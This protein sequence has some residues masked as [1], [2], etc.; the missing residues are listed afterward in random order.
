MNTERFPF[1]NARTGHFGKLRTS[2]ALVGVVAL[3]GATT[4]ACA[5]RV[6]GGTEAQPPSLSFGSDSAA[7]MESSAKSDA[8]RN[9]M[10]A[11]AGAPAAAPAPTGGGDAAQSSISDRMIVYNTSISLA[12]DNVQESVNAVSALAQ[13]AGGIVSG[14][15]I[16][17]DD[18]KKEQATLTLRVPS[19]SYYEVM[20]NLRKLGARVLNETGSTQDVTEEFTDLDA[21]LRNF[22]ATEAQYLELLKRAQTIDEILKVQNQLTQIRG[23]IERTKGRMNLL[24]RTSDMATIAVTMT[25]VTPGILQEPTNAWDPARTVRE[26]WETSLVFVRAFADVSIRVVIFSWWLLPFAALLWVAWTVRRR[27]PEPANPS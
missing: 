19:S 15:S 24:Q 12:V 14:T 10:G 22:Q 11:P 17:Y 26:A 16:R 4:L 20:N 5:S 1:D 9:A 18:K 3:L 7:T 23:Q 27:P 8:G 21:Q 6:P 13:G 2:L 25:P